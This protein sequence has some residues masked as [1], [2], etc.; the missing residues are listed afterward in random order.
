MG[1]QH[2]LAAAAAAAAVA[3]APAVAAA[4]PAVAVAAAVVCVI[5]LVEM[6]QLQ[7]PSVLTQTPVLDVDQVCFVCSTEPELLQ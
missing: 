5:G 1:P 6:E 7:I 3:A 4:A 2:F